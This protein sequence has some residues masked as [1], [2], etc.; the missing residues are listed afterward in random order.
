MQYSL[1][2]QGASAVAQTLGA[3]L[4]SYRDSNGTEYV[5][6]GDPCYWSSHAPV[7]FPIVGA[8]KSDTVTFKGVPYNMPKHGIVRKREW[9]FVNKTQNSVT[10]K[11]CS[12]AE[13]R[14]HFP[15]DFSLF[16]TH[17][18]SQNGFSTTYL[19][20]NTGNSALSV[21]IGG[22]A[23]FRCP[24]HDGETF[25][26]YTITFEQKENCKPLYTDIAGIL[27]KNQRTDVLESANSESVFPLKYS[28]FDNDVLV[29]DSLNS[30]SVIVQ[31]E[32]RGGGFRFSFDGF[33]HLGIWTPPHK[34]APFLCLEPWK[35][36]PAWE[37]ETGAFEDKPD[38]VCM[39]PHGMFTAGY[40]MEL[41]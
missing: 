31:N 8:L 34:N 33:N 22:H 7:L 19:V 28:A 27:H 30:R 26:D 21:C 12:D 25:E 11:I 32:K 3:E 20:E 13:I 38:I 16:V 29:F 35:G 40:K 15:Y 37:D 24:L 23:G 36:L 6:G 18:I 2:Y 10:F 14:N 4:I 39:D 5:W 1:S 17:A 9:E 41:I